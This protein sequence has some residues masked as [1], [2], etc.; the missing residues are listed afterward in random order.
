MVLLA[1]AIRP[2]ILL[3]KP[4]FSRPKAT[5]WLLR[6]WRK[7]FFGSLIGSALIVLGAL[8]LD[9]RGC[10]RLDVVLDGVLYL[11]AMTCVGLWYNSSLQPLMTAQPAASRPETRERLLIVGAGLEL[12]AYVSALSA[13]PESHFE[14]VG[15]ITHHRK[16]RT[17]MIGGI[18][19]LGELRDAPD[20]VKFSKITKVVAV[21]AW[22]DKSAVRYL[23]K[24]CKLTENQ[25][26]RVQ[27]LTPILRQCPT[28]AGESQDNN[29]DC[30]A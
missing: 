10:G 19:I 15:V 16:Y 14:I 21:G 25:V 8:L 4:V 26:L 7:L 3:F 18:P 20:I 22:S 9:E 23:R 1:A 24:K 29:G 2:G 6:E 13:L 27:L 17:N 5:S 28:D 11:F 30:H 12:T